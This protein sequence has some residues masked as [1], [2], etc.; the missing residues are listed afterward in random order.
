MKIAICDDEKIF[1][2]K[3][4][5][6]VWQEMDCTV[7]CFLSPLKL[8]EKYEAGSFYDVI[9]L[10]IKMKPMNGIELAQRLRSYDKHTAIIFL[11]AYAEYAPA[12]YEVRAFRYL[13]KPITKETVSQVMHELRRDLSEYQKILIKTPECTLLL[14]LNDIF[15]IEANNKDCIIHCLKETIMLRK[16]LV[17]LEAQLST[18]CFFRIHRK[19][20]IN[21]AHVREFDE[22]HLTLENGHTL[23]ISRRKNNSF[24]KAFDNYIEGGLHS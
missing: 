8:L 5:E 12:G 17:E 22:L 20:L 14:H 9:F 6:Y 10:D 3:L 15:Y 21:L 18:N 23:P 11:T 1:V 7:D 19:Y 2:E 13:L 4:K 16:G 24:R